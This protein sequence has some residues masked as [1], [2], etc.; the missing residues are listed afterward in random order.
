LSLP[1]ALSNSAITAISDAV[2]ALRAGGVIAY[3]TEYCFGLGC[4]PRNHD[5]VLRLLDIKR[6]EQA[7]GVIL[8]AAS[9][10]Q[11]AELADW[12]AVVRKEEISDSWPGPTTWLL[13]AKTNVATWIRGRHASVAMRIPGHLASVELCKQFGYPIVSTS[14]NRHGRPALL[15]AQ[16]VFNEMGS[17]LDFVLDL[18]VG[19]AESASTIKDAISG[20]SLR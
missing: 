19:G 9:L 3:P 14:A 4:D 12:E 8:I 5:A 2:G 18:P 17:E 7:Q 11:V 15:T 1:D 6:R 16:H 20:E 10:P 13:P